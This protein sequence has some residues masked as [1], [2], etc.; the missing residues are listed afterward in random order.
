MESS[1]DAEH[2]GIQPFPFK[3]D[4]V[5]KWPYKH[6]GKIMKYTTF[7]NWL[8]LQFYQTTIMPG[9]ADRVTYVVATSTLILNS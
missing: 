8:V 3:G 7:F 5:E 4:L 2:N 9:F 1:R 6:K